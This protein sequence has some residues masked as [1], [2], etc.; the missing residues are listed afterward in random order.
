MERKIETETQIN[1]KTQIQNKN[2]PSFNFYIR[3]S[4]LVCD[5]PH[6]L[7]VRCS[8]F[9]LVTRVITLSFLKLK[10]RE[11][12]SQEIYTC[13]L[14]TEDHVISEWFS[15][16]REGCGVSQRSSSRIYE[17]NWWFEWGR[18]DLLSSKFFVGTIII[19]LVQSIV[20]VFL[21]VVLTVIISFNVFSSS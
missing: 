4:I 8:T 2:F 6:S 16:R 10:N 1:I 7:H 13:S 12:T 19:V 11:R 14:L 17:C 9:Y 5:A 3:C 21:Q 18:R 20:L 15:V